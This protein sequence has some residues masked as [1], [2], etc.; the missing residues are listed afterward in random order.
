MLFA[1]VHKGAF[2]LLFNQTG[3]I[4][5]CGFIGVVFVP[6]LRFS[7]AQ[8]SHCPIFRRLFQLT[9]FSCRYYRESVIDVRHDDE[10]Y[11]QRVN[12]PCAFRTYFSYTH[13]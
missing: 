3:A 13:G 9:F 8:F 4:F 11:K 7:V 6:M 5:F 10:K 12:W 2:V 1:K